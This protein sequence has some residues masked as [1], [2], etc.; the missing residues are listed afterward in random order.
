M[1]ARTTERQM[2]NQRAVYVMHDQVRY[3]IDC[4]PKSVRDDRIE[5]LWEESGSSLRYWYPDKS[6]FNY[7]LLRSEA[8]RLNPEL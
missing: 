7:S 6:N 2:M 3:S 5:R 1:N 4:V 8:A